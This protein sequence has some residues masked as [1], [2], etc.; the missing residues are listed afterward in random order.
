MGYTPVNSID[1]T[2]L[3]LDVLAKKQQ[4]IGANLA[5]I[6]TPGYQRQDISF[7]QYIG[8]LNSPLETQLSKKMGPSAVMTSQGGEV[9]QANEMVQMQ[10]VAL[11]YSMAIRQVS[12]KITEI[13][14]VIQVGK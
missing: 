10:Q 13:K 11:Y 4:V 3:V 12:S 5:N 8:S 2:N 14:Q 6:D 9:N 7:E 1:K